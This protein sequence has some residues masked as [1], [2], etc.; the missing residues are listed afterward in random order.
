MAAAQCREAD[1]C[2]L[3]VSI[4]R[5]P[6]RH[7]TTTAVHKKNFYTRQRGAQAPS[8]VSGQCVVISRYLPAIITYIIHVRYILQVHFYT[9]KSSKKLVS[10]FLWPMKEI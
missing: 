7:V 2:L 8:G 4:A 9:Q 5:V 10:H 1:D 6:A 3:S